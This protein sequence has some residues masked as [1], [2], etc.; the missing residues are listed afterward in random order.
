MFP[1]TLYC[2]SKKC[3]KNAFGGRASPRTC[4]GAYSSP[5]DPLAELK[6]MEWETG[7]ERKGRGWKSK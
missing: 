4:W 3:T 7:G 5:P 1:E 2:T 6:G